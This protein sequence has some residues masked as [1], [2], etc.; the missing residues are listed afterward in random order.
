MHQPR[1]LDR[2]RDA[3][4]VRHYSLRTEQAYTH[5]IKRFIL[6]HDKR[7][8][9]SMGEPEI[10]AFLTYLAV[11]RNVAASTQNQA[12]S[13][14]LFLYKQVLKQDLDWLDSIVRA[15]RPSRLPTVLTAQE[16]QALLSHLKGTNKLIAELLYGTGMRLMECL[17]LRVKDVDFEY[18]QITVRGGK[19]DKDRVTVLPVRTIPELRSQMEHTKRLHALD[20]GEGFGEV[21][22]PFAL[23]RKYPKAGR[24][25]GWQF[26]F[27]SKSRSVD[28][29]S[30]A[31][32]RHH[33]YEKNVQRALKQAARNM[34]LTKP[35][36]SHTLRHSFA[37]CLLARGYDIR[38]IQELLGHKDVKTT[39][40]YTH[41]MNR[42]AQ[43]VIS[44]LDGTDDR[45]L[46]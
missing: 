28:P 35:V 41:V 34:G 36:S 12:L 33:F 29:Q 43:G 31:I 9:E 27:A 19:G 20:L 11:Q 18:R 30:G 16:T 21:Y 23:A 37:T 46:Q 1:L 22:L 44:P 39:M 26:V 4:R 15:K 5:W 40:V 8:P 17:R 6:F 3:L 32:R 2:V 25:W 24:D 7:H 45:P 10:T 13:A 38:T 42:G 14:I